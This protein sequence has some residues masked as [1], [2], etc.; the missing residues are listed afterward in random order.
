MQTSVCQPHLLYQSMDYTTQTKH[1]KTNIP[2]AKVTN[3]V[4]RGHMFSARVKVDSIAS[5]G[6]IKTATCLLEKSAHLAKKT[7]LAAR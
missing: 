2:H 7:H 6:E 4:Y 5:Q 1:G 3:F